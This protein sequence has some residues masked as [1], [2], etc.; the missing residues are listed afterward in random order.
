MKKILLILGITLFIYGIYT[1]PAEASIISDRTYRAEQRKEIKQDIKQI[2]ELFNTHNKYAN[3][4]DVKNLAALYS[5]KYMN[6]DGFNKEVY[7]KSIESTWKSC[8]TLTYTT[9]II[10]MDITGDY[11][12]VN[13][14]ETASGTVIENYGH[15][16]I[17]GEI[18]SLSKGTYHLERVNGKWYI[19]G[20]TSISDESSLLYGDARFMNLE[21]QTPAQVSSGET[22][23]ASLKIDADEDTFIL[24]SIDHDPVTYPA[25]P[26]KSEL[27]TVPSSQ[28]LERV[29]KANSDN[30]NE[31][32]V[33]SLV[34]SKV[35][36]PTA[37]QPVSNVRM[38]G[39]VCLMKRIN[40]VPVN[41]FINPEEE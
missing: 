26:P 30:V 9:K 22:Y 18:H 38:V 24:A 8:E 13:V 21:L 15:V 11:A 5:D 31:Y 20:E 27:R 23:T 3:A 28:I 36:N 25:K 32:A 41:D 34:V 37:F 7:F 17:A 4:H 39:L 12:S 1:V 10:S 14:E 2:K 19:A 29:L 40:V 35:N 6:N 33:A 16:P